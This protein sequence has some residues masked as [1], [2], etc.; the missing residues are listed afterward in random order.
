MAVHYLVTKYYISAFFVVLFIF[1]FKTRKNANVIIVHYLR[2]SNKK[3]E[4]K[5]KNEGVHKMVIGS[6]PSRTRVG[7]HLLQS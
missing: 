4:V 7:V 5:P 6:V 3:S 1:P 2:Y